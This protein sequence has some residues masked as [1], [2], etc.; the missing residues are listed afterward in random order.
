MLQVPPDRLEALIPNMFDPNQMMMTDVELQVEKGLN[1]RAH[2]CMLAFHS[3]VLKAALTNIDVRICPIP[4]IYIQGFHRD[5]VRNLLHFFYKGVTEDIAWGSQIQ[6]DFVKLMKTLGVN[7]KVTKDLHPPKSPSGSDDDEGDVSDSQDI[8]GD[9][10]TALEIDDG[11]EMVEDDQ[12][13]VANDAVLGITMDVKDNEVA[14]ENDSQENVLVDE[15]A[16]HSDIDIKE[17]IVGQGEEEEKDLELGDQIGQEDI[18]KEEEN[19]NVTPELVNIDELG[20]DTSDLD[21]AS[22]S[23]DDEP[24]SATVIDK[25]SS[26]P[27]IGGDTNLCAKVVNEQPN[28]I[29]EEKNVT[30][31]ERTGELNG[32]GDEL[33]EICNKDFLNG[34]A[35][36]D[37]QERVKAAS[38][39]IVKSKPERFVCD[40]CVEVF[41]V[42]K[43]LDEHKQN[44]HLIDEISDDD[45]QEE[46]TEAISDFLSRDL[47]IKLKEPEPHPNVSETLKEDPDKGPNEDL[48]IRI[49]NVS[50]IDK[51]DQFELDMFGFG[52]TSATTD[53]GDA[54]DSPPELEPFEFKMPDSF[55]LSVDYIKEIVPSKSSNKVEYKSSEDEKEDAD[56]FIGLNKLEFKM[57]LSD[58]SSEIKEELDNQ[59]V[60]DE[61]PTE[62]SSGRQSQVSSTTDNNVEAI[63]YKKDKSSK[64]SMR[65]REK[66]LESRRDRKKKD[67]K[68]M[69]SLFG[70]DDISEGSAIKK[71]RNSSPTKDKKERPS[72]STERKSS[73]SLKKERVAE[74]DDRK[75]LTPSPDCRSSIS[76]TRTPTPTNTMSISEELKEKRERMMRKMKFDDEEKLDEKIECR[77][78]KKE[79]RSRKKESSPRKKTSIGGTPKK[80]SHHKNCNSSCQI[81]HRWS[82]EESWLVPDDYESSS[83]SSVDLLND[84]KRK[85]KKMEESKP[86]RSKSRTKHVEEIKSEA[87][88]E[89]DFI[90][91]EDEYDE[92]EEDE[93]AKRKRDKRLSERKKKAGGDILF[94]MNPGHKSK[95]KVK[96]QMFAKEDIMDMNYYKMKLL[97]DEGSDTDVETPRKVSESDV[98]SE[99]SSKRSK[100]PDY[101]KRMLDN[102]DTDNSIAKRKKHKKRKKKKRHSSNG[103]PGATERYKRPVSD[104][105]DEDVKPK[106]KFKSFHR[107]VS[108]VGSLGESS[109]R[110]NS[111]AKPVIQRSISTLESLGISHNYGLSSM[112]KLTSS[113]P[114]IP[115]I[116]KPSTEMPKIP[117]IEKPNTTEMPKI[118]KMAKIPKIL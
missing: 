25:H 67:R 38:T 7:P 113:M 116:A 35:I 43:D 55:D 94:W 56:G 6:G 102:S 2:K 77:D 13:E 84:L 103:S 1:F 15:N 89:E 111:F 30:S 14:N 82:D 19:N 3:P 106:S 66:P 53:I 79:K 5:S 83:D 104:S 86:K 37:L 31:D 61:T 101:V 59:P 91:D 71:E 107:S 28:V 105:S 41:S 90:D 87:D 26:D 68:L 95:V 32:A 23:T 50:S 45:T 52:E 58:L 46:T 112:P 57:P 62:T 29:S 40:I 75:F 85:I 49:E 98:S 108:H 60:P 78:Y 48:N 96:V 109:N 110:S 8:D 70:S 80:S 54:N 72:S 64:S 81:D 44:I 92:D 36:Q 76:P 74:D 34:D 33:G 18:T 42:S 51:N 24:D 117:K 100:S 20:L 97:A 21:D 27:V 12:E 65:S 22:V 99:V 4:V 47:G 118:P 88:S 114:K 17:T 73:K 115:K 69:N 10:G 93:E 63:T 11:G 16:G 39:G 9:G